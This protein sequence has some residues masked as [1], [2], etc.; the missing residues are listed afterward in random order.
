ML[1]ENRTYDLK[2][3]VPRYNHYSARPTYVK[4]SHLNNMQLIPS[5]RNFIK[6]HQALY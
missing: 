3:N 2:D 1:K 5:L 6:K 4:I